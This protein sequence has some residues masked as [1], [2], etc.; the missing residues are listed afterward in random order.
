MA[1]R[2]APGD[3]DQLHH[4]VTAG[5]WDSAPLEMELLIHADKLVGGGDA[6]MVID[7]TAVPKKG[8]HSVG[9]A[10]RRHRQY[11]CADQKSAGDDPHTSARIAPPAMGRSLDAQI[12]HPFH[13]NVRYVAQFIAHHSAGDDAEESGR[14][15]WAQPRSLLPAVDCARS[16]RRTARRPNAAG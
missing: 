2:L 12:K 13:P 7:D 16:T 6:V 14:M 9:V 10:S 4:F 11:G 8:K 15:G 5:V 1:E 3:Y